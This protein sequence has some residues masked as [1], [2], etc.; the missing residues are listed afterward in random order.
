MDSVHPTNQT[1]PLNMAEWG[2]GPP[3]FQNRPNNLPESPAESVQSVEWNVPI[4]QY[5]PEM[6][7]SQNPYY[8]SI[9]KLLFEM[10]LERQQRNGNL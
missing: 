1:L 2:P 10:Y 9:N 3:Y 4:P 6:T 5:N 8:Y 7:E